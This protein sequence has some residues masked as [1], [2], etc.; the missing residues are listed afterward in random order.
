LSRWDINGEY[1]ITVVFLYSVYPLS[2][3]DKKGEYMLVLDRECIFNPVKWFLS[4]NG[5]M[6]SL[7]VFVLAAF[8]WTKS[9]LFNV[10]TFTRMLFISEFSRYSECISLIWKEPH[11]D[12]LQVSQASRRLF[13]CSW[14]ILCRFLLR[15]VGSQAS[16][17][18]TQYNVRMLNSQQHL[19]GRRELSVRTPISV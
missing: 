1:F 14:K 12:K 15:K 17:R 9:L 13:Q 7:L 19:F 2:L 3:W 11:Y 10:A 16:V 18:T 6:G 8:C 4:H 5:Q